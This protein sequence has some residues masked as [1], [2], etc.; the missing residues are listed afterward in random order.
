MEDPSVLAPAALVRLWFERPANADSP[1]NTAANP[2]RGRSLTSRGR[3]RELRD[4][5]S[6]GFVERKSAVESEHRAARF[7]ERG[8]C[9]LA[10][11]T[12]LSAR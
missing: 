4:H 3:R 1:V 8:I 9:S 12:L 6:H 10:P 2:G 11:R 7:G 5:A